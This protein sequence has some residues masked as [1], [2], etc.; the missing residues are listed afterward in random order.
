MSFKG[1][2][3]RFVQLVRRTLGQRFHSY[4]HTLC[5]CYR[6]MEGTLETV[7]VL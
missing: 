3:E 4:G 7:R 5:L 6:L 2:L 1:K